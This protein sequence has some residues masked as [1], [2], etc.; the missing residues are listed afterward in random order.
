MQVKIQKFQKFF[1]DSLIL[2]LYWEN[3]IDLIEGEPYKIDKK[4]TFLTL[5]RKFYGKKIRNLISL[6]KNKS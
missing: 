5:V 6:L 1:E 4:I 2:Q 3:T